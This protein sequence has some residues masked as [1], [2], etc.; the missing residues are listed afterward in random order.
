MKRREEISQMAKVYAHNEA[1][2]E[3]NR[4]MTYRDFVNGAEQA[5]KTNALELF[6]KL[7]HLD[8][9]EIIVA[10]WEYTPNLY[11]FDQSWH[12]SW[13]GCLEGDTFVDFEAET[14]E[15]AIKKA[16]DWCVKLKLIEK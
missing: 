15:E 16:F 1:I 7:P 9:N 4:L 13:I 6:K 2:G 14:P 12:V 5:D 10:D 3:E 11:H 8:S